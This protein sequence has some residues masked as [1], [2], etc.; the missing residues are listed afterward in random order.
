M[1]WPPCEVEDRPELW[2]GLSWPLVVHEVAAAAGRTGSN[3]VAINA[4]IA[5][6]FILNLL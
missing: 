6:S 2:F 1:T 3:E 4:R 5:R